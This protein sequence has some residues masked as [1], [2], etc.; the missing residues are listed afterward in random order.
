M[1]ATRAISTRAM[2]TRAMSTRCP[3]PAAAAH[4][5]RA[6]PVRANPP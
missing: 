5:R 2:S 6:P 3:G 1:M 4:R